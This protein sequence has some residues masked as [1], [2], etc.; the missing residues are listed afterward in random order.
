MPTK[1]QVIHDRVEAL[2]AEGKSRPEAFEIVSTEQ[3]IKV[4][5]ARGAY[6]QH[7]RG[8]QPG[9]PRRRETTP[10]DALAD[11]RAA[12]QRGIDSIDRETDA[13]KARMEESK[14]EYE[15]LKATAAEKKAA[16][17]ERLEALK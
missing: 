12:L 10:D 11:A 2:V 1:A 9:K 13:A 16:I 5:S 4:N 7:A 3:S 8:G 14:A 6:Y 15:S 17:T